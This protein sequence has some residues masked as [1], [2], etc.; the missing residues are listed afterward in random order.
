MIAFITGATGFI[1]SNLIEALK[2]DHWQIRIL[3]RKKTI[4]VANDVEVIYGELADKGAVL[5]GVNGV[6]VVFNLAAIL[7]HQKKS[8]DEYF[9][10]NVTGVKNIIDACLK[11]KV[12]RLVH[13]STVG[14]YGSSGIKVI[15]EKSERKLLDYYSQSKAKAEDLIFSYIKKYKLKATIIRPTIAFGPHDKRPGFSSLFKLV[16]KRMFI[17][18]GDGKNY[19]HTVYV[20]NLVDALILAAVS[21]KALGKDFIIGDDPCPT[22]GEIIK[23]IYEA[24]GLKAPKVYLPIFFAIVAAKI[25]DL[26][27]SLGLPA[28][29]NS[30]RLAFITENR[31]YSIEKAKRILGFKPQVSLSEAI[32]QTQHWYKQNGYL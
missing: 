24:E 22:I 16:H 27:S 15:N 13:V 23:E 14:I 18:V 2:K 19:L 1:G 10:V 17:P 28:P 6:D 26:T 4:Q 11:N 5:R 7:P 20:K 25:F 31:R 21:K 8:K 12:R 30:K 3:V 29:L 9:S 32:K